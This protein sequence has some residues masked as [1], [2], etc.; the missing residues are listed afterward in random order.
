MGFQADADFRGR[1]G[2]G[3]IAV[4]D[5]LPGFPET[6]GAVQLAVVAHEDGAPLRPSVQQVAV[7]DVGPG[8]GDFPLFLQDPAEL[9]GVFFLDLAEL[10]GEGVVLLAAGEIQEDVRSAVGFR[11]VAAEAFHKLPGLR[12]LRLDLGQTF[13]LH[14]AQR[15]H[16]LLCLFL[17]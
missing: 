16:H 4:P 1:E 8:D 17:G 9:Q 10:L 2:K 3:V 6:R 15:T 14:D 11:Q 5:R 13:V 12:E 7:Q